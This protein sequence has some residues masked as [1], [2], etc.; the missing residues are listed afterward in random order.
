MID[1]DVALT[2]YADTLADGATPPPG[3]QL[4]TRSA[5]VEKESVPEVLQILAEVAASK[6]V[7][8]HRH[9][10]RQRCGI[11]SPQRRH[12]V[13]PPP[14]GVDVR[15]RSPRVRS[16]SSR[17][18]R[19]R[20]TRSGQDWHLTS[21][22]PTQ[23]SS[24]LPPRR[25]SPRSTRRRPISG[26]RRS[27]AST[28][29]ATCS[30]ATTTSGRPRPDWTAPATHGQRTGRPAPQYRSRR[31]PVRTRPQPRGR[32]SDQSG[33]RHDAHQSELGAPDHR[34]GCAAR[35]HPDHGRRRAVP[36]PAG[37]VHRER[38][39]SADRC[40]FRFHRGRPDLGDQRLRAHLR[41]AARWRDTNS[42]DPGCPRAGFPFVALV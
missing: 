20:W 36:G 30:L 31:D 34:P 6:A 4:V 22:V 12:R 11:P 27:S 21:T 25:M 16:Q 10:Q 40:R 19:R 35:C 13:R 38:C 42:S 7:A 24:P 9:A 32:R 18:L 17:P 41:R 15:R 3:I 23:T 14:G 2:P 1:D 5:F 33:P 26:S 8:G 39:S 28:T 37:P 29:P